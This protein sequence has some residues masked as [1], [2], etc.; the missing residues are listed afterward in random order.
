MTKFRKKPV[1]I[2][3]IQNDGNWNTIINWLEENPLF[4]SAPIR[5][6]PDGTLLID[7]LEGTMRGLV[8]D[9][10]IKGVAGEFYACKPDIFKETYILVEED[11]NDE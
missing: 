8:G 4:F 9:W 3:A 7:T 1:E 11:D 5:R 10:I 6:E 2:E